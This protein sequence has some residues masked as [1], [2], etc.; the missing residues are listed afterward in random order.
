ML[1]LLQSFDKSAS[2]TYTKPGSCLQHAEQRLQEKCKPFSKNTPIHPPLIG[3]R[4]VF[5]KL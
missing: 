2:D 4:F 3:T 1:N 5:I